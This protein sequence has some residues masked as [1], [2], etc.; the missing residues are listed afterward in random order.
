MLPSG[1]LG[2]AL[3]KSPGSLA[4]CRDRER[5]QRLDDRIV[6]VARAE[7][8]R[9]EFLWLAPREILEWMRGALGSVATETTGQVEH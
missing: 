9:G 4:G 5:T 7:R 1:W 3:G 6:R 8:D 2:T